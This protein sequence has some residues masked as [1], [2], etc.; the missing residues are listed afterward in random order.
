MSANL[1]PTPKQGFQYQVK[2]GDRLDF[3]EKSAYG[4][5]TGL[6]EGANPFLAKRQISLENRPIIIAGDILNIPFLPDLKKLKTKLTGK[7][8]NTMTIV[9]GDREINYISARLVRTMDTAADG[10]T[11]VISWAPG[12]DPELDELIKPFQYPDVQV[13]IGN[14]LLLSGLLYGVAPEVSADGITATL[15]IWSYTADMIDSDVTE[16][17]EANNITLQDWANQKLQP[18]GI[19]A[20][21]EFDPGGPFDRITADKGTKIFDSLSELAAQRGLLLTSDVQGN[22]LFTKAKTGAP[23]GTL[24][25]GQAGPLGWGA[26]FDGRVLFNS[27]TAYGESPGSPVKS[28]Q[29]ID[30][31]V[32]RSRFMSF[33]ADDT[34]DGDIQKAA[35]WKRAKLNAQAL[36][37]PFPVSYW[38]APNGTIYRENTSITIKSTE[39]FVPNGF[40]F[41]ITRV[42]YLAE[43]SGLTS[44]LQLLP[45]SVYNGDNLV[46]PWETT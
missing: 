5:V 36:T 26:K 16:P 23:V 38:Y 37:I 1:S 7:D 6:I 25:S 46:F 22:A 27:I 29:S 21:F 20:I 13:F 3:I 14:E 32:P 35:D 4:Y 44:I 19:K 28:A 34:T 33:K 41:L 2:Y 17:L 45:P 24:E 39:I 11:C 15:E 31:N 8:K 30:E 9:I 18:L 12:K 43:I 40:D 42:E 10:C